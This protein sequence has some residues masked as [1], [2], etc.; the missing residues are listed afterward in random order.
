MLPQFELSLPI[1]I[2]FGR[3]TN[4]DHFYLLFCFNRSQIAFIS[5]KVHPFCVLIIN[6]VM[7]PLHYGWSLI[8][9]LRK[10]VFS[11]ARSTIASC[12]IHSITRSV[13]CAREFG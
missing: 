5:K 9:S 13:L 4:D 11:F 7:K 1:E 2:E 12:A 3:H 8:Y 6:T 10:H